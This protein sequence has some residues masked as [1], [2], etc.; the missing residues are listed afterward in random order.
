MW[1]ALHRPARADEQPD[2]AKK[3]YQSGAAAY[4]AGAFASA[5]TEFRVAYELSHKAPI[6]WDIARAESRLG[7]DEIAVEF[8]KRYAKEDPNSPDIASVTAEI[9]ARE[10]AIEEHKQKTRAEVEAEVARRQ[11]ELAKQQTE[12]AQKEASRRPR[13]P[14]YALVGAGAAILV[15]GIALNAV[16]AVDSNQVSDGGK[17]TPVP[18]SS[19]F[20]SKESTGKIAAPLGIAFDVIGAACLATGVGL[21]IWARPRADVKRALLMPAPGGLAVKESEF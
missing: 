14:G 21:W 5:A 18:F 6:L 2:E 8:L 9:E 1:V 19:G 7:H 16:A 11:T 4:Q 20:S 10:R 15:A 3:R 17:P 12:A 13:S